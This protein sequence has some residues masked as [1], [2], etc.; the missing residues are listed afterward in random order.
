MFAADTMSNPKPPP[1]PLPAQTPHPIH[2]TLPTRTY[3]TPHRQAHRAAR[4]GRPDDVVLPLYGVAFDA[5]Y[6]A[7]LP[8]LMSG[9]TVLLRE[10]VDPR[11]RPTV[12]AGTPSLV[13][14]LVVQGAPEL[15]A[16]VRL[17]Q[18]GSG[19]TVYPSASVAAGGHQ[20]LDLPLAPA[21]GTCRRWDYYQ[22]IW[23]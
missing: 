8:A 15:L 20:I 6:E 22:M 7:T 3:A 12:V 13:A 11:D 16:D 23:L 1:S 10:H 5:F 14:T 21:R 19:R 18:V 17:C 2:A 4:F 9:S